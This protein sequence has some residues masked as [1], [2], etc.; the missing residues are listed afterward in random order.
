M[1][2]ISEIYAR[3]REE[4]SRRSED[5]AGVL[6]KG[7]DIRE[8]LKKL[9]DELKAEGNLDWSRRR[10]SGEILEKQKEIQSKMREITGEIDKSLET[11]EKN[12]AASQE[13]GRKLEEIK[14]L[15][16]QI[17]N[18]DLRAAIEKLQKLM[19]DVPA[20]ISPPR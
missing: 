11:I 8:R 4:E 10:E 12:R 14:K 3:I 13:V 7:R 16:T 18:E 2:S 17:E 5:L 1:P 20:A 15:L 9:S 6:D 19:G